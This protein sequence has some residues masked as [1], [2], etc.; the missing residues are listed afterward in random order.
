MR[1]TFDKSVPLAEQIRRAG[2]RKS[3]GRKHEHRL[4]P[5]AAAEKAKRRAEF[6]NAKRAKWWNR[7]SAEVAK[8]WSGARDT[9]P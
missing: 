3:V 8:Y 1:L 5:S 4:G 7:Y 2:N 9:H 6:K